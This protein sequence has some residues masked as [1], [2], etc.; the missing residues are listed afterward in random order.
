MKNGHNLYLTCNH[1]IILN[2]QNK[3]LAKTVRWTI[4]HYILI[5]L[6][7]KAKATIPI[8]AS[9][10]LFSKFKNAYHTQNR[11]YDADGELRKPGH[12]IKYQVLLYI[13][14]H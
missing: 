10:E 14:P 5:V 2:T 6:S 11:R 3:C 13:L 12:Y 8:A 1:T 4:P 7:H 9:S